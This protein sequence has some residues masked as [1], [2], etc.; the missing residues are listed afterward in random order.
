MTFAATAGKPDDWENN[1][2]TSIANVDGGNGISFEQPILIASAGELAYFARQ[3]NDGGEELTVGNG[4]SIDKSST[5]GTSGFSGNYFALSADI[6]L[7]G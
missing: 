5:S 3:V 2:A 6:D 4:E 1:A 7:E